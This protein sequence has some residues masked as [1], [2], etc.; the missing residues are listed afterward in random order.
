MPVQYSATDRH[1]LLEGKFSSHKSVNKIK[2]VFDL[3]SKEDRDRI[4]NAKTKS[5]ENDRFTPIQLGAKIEMEL[6]AARLKVC[7]YVHCLIQ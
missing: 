7:Y 2:S 3:I 6:K 5:S 4:E 1:A